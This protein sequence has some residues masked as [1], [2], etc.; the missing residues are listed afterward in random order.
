MVGTIEVGG[1]PQPVQ[2]KLVGAKFLNSAF[3]SAVLTGMNLKG[4]NFQGANLRSADLR[5]AD[6]SQVDL[7]GANLSG[8]NLQ[9]ANLFE[10]DLTDANLAGANL[11]YTSLNS[12]TLQ[13]AKLVTRAD[14][15]FPAD[16]TYSEFVSFIFSQDCNNGTFLVVDNGQVEE[17]RLNF[18]FDL[19]RSFFDQDKW[20][21]AEIYICSANLSNTT[22][23]GRKTRETSLAG[24]NMR[25]ADLSS[26]DL[27]NLTFEET[28]M[29]GSIPYTLKADLTGV[30]YDSFTIWPR[31][32]NYPA[33][34]K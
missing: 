30:I 29:V 26:S 9:R 31:G 8:A 1:S 27:S 34:A 28:I 19:G 4:V 10:T 5:E 21:N 18:A 14:V 33:S 22:M 13:D 17:R 2:T 3:P 23:R 6:L 12:V 7:S 11:S 25:G 32:F 24:I 16:L 15:N 20:R